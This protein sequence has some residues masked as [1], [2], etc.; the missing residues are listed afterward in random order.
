MALIAKST[1]LSGVYQTLTLGVVFTIVHFSH[2][3]VFAGLRFLIFLLLE[4]FIIR[5]V[6]SNR[7]DVVLVNN[8]KSHLDSLA[9]NHPAYQN[10]VDGT[11][12]ESD[13][14]L[15]HGQRTSR[16]QRIEQPLFL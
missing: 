11:G 10:D 7:V 5:I 15:D 9:S 14:K 13:Q 6:G 1:L 2:L 16:F 3:K 8:E 4:A 12:R